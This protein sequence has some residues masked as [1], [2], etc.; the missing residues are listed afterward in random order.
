MCTPRESEVFRY[1]LKNY[2]TKE[3]AYKMSISDKTVRNHISNVILKLN[4]SSRTQA[5]LELLRCHQIEL[6]E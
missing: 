2:S 5:V 6:D 4:V 1:L 3:I